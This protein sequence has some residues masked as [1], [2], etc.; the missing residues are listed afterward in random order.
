MKRILVI[1]DLH[2]GHVAG[3]TPPRWQISPGSEKNSTKREKFAAFQ[4]EAWNWYVRKT[5]A[6]GPYD[7]VVCNG[8]AID[9]RG[10]RSGGTELIVSDR[11]E[12]CDMATYCIQRVM[13]RK[14]K[15][16]MTYGTAYHTGDKEDWEGGIAKGL[17]G[18]IGAHEWIDAEGVVFDLKHHIGSSD[19]PY[20]R[21]TQSAKQA[22]W[23]LLW[24]EQALT[25]KADILLRSHVHYLQACLDEAMRPEWRFTTPALQGMGSKFGARRCSG[26]VSFGFL[27]F[28]VRRGRYD[29][30]KV[31]EKLK[32]SVA[33]AIKV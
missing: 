2:C 26:V 27:V 14:T 25:P 13:G 29:W 16:I 19:V 23:S 5:S 8:D 10:E 24:A 7:V 28:E 6:H 11:E 30:H 18:K 3:L 9:G 32:S 31:T 1:A 21:H 33:K 17:N 4:K 22:L 20:G 12:Q 15:L